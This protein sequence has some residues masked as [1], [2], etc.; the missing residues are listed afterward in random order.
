MRSVFSFL[1]VAL[2]GLTHVFADNAPVRNATIREINLGLCDNIECRVTATVRDAF[3][4]DVDRNFVQLTLVQDRASCSVFCH[5]PT[6]GISNLVSL[7]GAKVRVC[8]YVDP[9]YAKDRGYLGRTLCCCNENHSVD[10]L[11]EASDDLCTVPSVESIL[12]TEPAELFSLGPHKTDGIVL[13]VWHGSELLLRTVQ[14]RFMRVHL[15]SR[16]PPSVGDI[17]TVSGFPEISFFHL[18]LSNAIWKPS[19]NILQTTSQRVADVVIDDVMSFYDGRKRYSSDLYGSS[20]RISGT[21][22]NLSFDDNPDAT[23]L[24]DVQGHV[25]PVFAKQSYVVGLE[26]GCVL[27]ITGTLILDAESW[28]PT[29][30]QHAIRRLFV[31]PHGK[32][33][34]HVLKSPPWWTLA[35]LTVMFCLILAILIAALIHLRTI[36][37][38]TVLKVNERTRIAIELHDSVAQSLTG[39]AMRLEAAKRVINEGA[40]AVL[41]HL[42]VGIRTLKSCRDDL[43]NCL[44]DLRNP[45]IENGDFNAAIAYTL[46]P[47]IEPQGVTVRIRFNIPRKALPDDIAHVLLN[48]V[49]ELT[50]NAARHG[51]S[52]FIHVA[53]SLDKTH[54]RCS[55]SDNG[56]GFDPDMAPGILQGHF[57]I[58]GI[59]ERINRLNGSLSIRPNK[60]RGMHIKF[61]IPRSSFRPVAP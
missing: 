43:R 50:V 30:P 19:T 33:D 44:W 27:E 20:I 6:R 45:T 58:Q 11:H 2:G 22:I 17:I 48:I 42:D 12:N 1:L 24:I 57:G 26:I 46:K 39:V 5:I 41:Q 10:T 15:R 13:A 59:R 4:D 40:E 25:I 36:R 7:I 21:L 31:I 23:L 9:F 16:Y 28:H 37:L 61:S 38:K 3:E 55:V 52:T 34:I 60:R 53:G 49:R 29:A 47:H 32:T 14:D 54:L 51:G 35:R 56:C 8:G 18:N